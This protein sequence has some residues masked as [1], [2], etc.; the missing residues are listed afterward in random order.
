MAE[1]TPTDYAFLVLLKIEGREVSNT[2]LSEL[3][4]VR[5]IGAN[6]ARL[7]G[8]GCV[9]SD[10]KHRPYRHTIDAK[11]SKVLD[12]PLE[13][14]EDGAQGKE[15]KRTDRE[16]QLWAALSA[17][18]AYHLHGGTRPRTPGLDERIRAAYA[19]LATQPGAWVSLS[20][21]RPLFDEVSKADLDTAL[22]RLL[23]APDVNL[24]P[25]P[26]QKTLTVKD[27]RAAVRIG[28]EDRHLLAIGMR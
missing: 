6:L 3:H 17:L 25:E 20:R 13:L 9:V 24:E 8:A 22:R 18:H 14:A 27:R 5:L 1:L 10:T 21:L 28:G 7:N 19:D 2:E 16:K 23:D 26:N 11:G 12:G 4:G 15:D